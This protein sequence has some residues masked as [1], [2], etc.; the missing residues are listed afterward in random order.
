VSHSSALLPLFPDT[1]EIRDGVLWIGGHSAVELAEEYGTPL[2]VYCEETIRNAARAWRRG[3]G[4]RTTTPVRPG[5]GVASAGPCTVGRVV[6][7]RQPLDAMG[8]SP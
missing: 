5:W 8:R 1:A 2:V 4:E 3:A 6:P 7:A